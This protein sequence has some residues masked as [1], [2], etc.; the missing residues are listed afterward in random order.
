MRRRPQ[1]RRHSSS[2]NLTDEQIQELLDRIESEDDYRRARLNSLSVYSSS[3]SDDDILNEI[4]R[5]PLPTEVIYMLSPPD[6]QMAVDSLVFLN[7]RPSYDD[8][9]QR[10]AEILYWMS[11]GN[12]YQ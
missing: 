8:E 2:S 7:Q 4:K 9:Q 12:P 3:D 1:R 10:A 5:E 11:R 6:E